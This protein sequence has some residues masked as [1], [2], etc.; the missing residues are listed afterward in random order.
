MINVAVADDHEMFRRGLKAALGS[1][2]DINIT[3]D[4]ANGNEAMDLLVTQPVDVLLADI[5][6]PHMDGVEI[7]EAISLK[8]INVKVVLISSFDNEDMILKCLAKGAKGFLSKNEDADN[9]Y[10]AIKGV[11]LGGVYF[12]E[13]VNTVMI[14]KLLDNT[15]S[16]KRAVIDFVE[17]TDRELDV[18]NCILKENTLE[19]IAQNCNMTPANVSVIKSALKK[20]T[21]AKSTTGLVLWAIKNNLVK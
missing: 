9:I 12:N 21:G 15:N 1:Y 2:E 6:M 11:Q 5:G 16:N 19:Q 8:K 14:T 10:N 4:A 20:K 18:L 17:L 3:W 7:L 13:L